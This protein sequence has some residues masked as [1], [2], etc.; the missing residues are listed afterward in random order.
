M[1]ER[2]RVCPVGFAAEFHGV[3]LGDERLNQRL[4]RFAAQCRAAPE[5]SFP[6]IA[7]SQ[8]DLT[9]TYRFL[10]SPTVTLASVLEPHIVATTRRCI[11]AGRVLVIHDTSECEFSGEKRSGLG[12]LRGHDQGFLLHGSLALAADGSRRPLGILGALT[13][14]R[15]ER[16]GTKRPDGARKTGGDY[17]RE[18]GKES[19]RW[20]DTVLGVE[21][22]L[23]EAVK[24]IH[25]MDREADAFHFLRDAIEYGARFV[26]RMAR[27]RVLLDCDDD[28]KLGKTSEVLAACTDIFEL[29]VPLS[30]RAAKPMP[31]S[32]AP[33]EARKAKLAVTG[34]KTRI[35]RPN[36]D[37]ESAE[38]LEVNLVC[39]REVDPPSHGDAVDW[40]LITTEPIDTP[41]QLR[42]V[43][44]AYR[45]RWMIEE[46]F[47]ALKTG[48]AFE[49][50][51][52]ESYD[53][54]TSA[55]GIFLPIAWHLLLLRHDA[56]NTP[57]EPAE[58]VLSPIQLQVLRARLPQIVPPRATASDVLR[59]IAYLGGH[60]T[61]KK[62]G[63]LVLGRGLEK[64]LDLEEG[65]RL[66]TGADP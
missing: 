56:H 1:R 6:D 60:F 11:E 4:T 19:A 45:A 41:Q 62:P 36:Y 61:K 63:W 66:A 5:R 57:R 31:K 9:A 39:V 13:W 54:L 15:T 28:S 43:V 32:P 8:A 29:D 42:A 10:R 33:R 65:W 12:T 50:R 17:H 40:V 55:L 49:K 64:L 18:S 21:Q 51:Q 38:S 26:V 47:K 53:T 24:A 27:D 46:L 25:V 34:T 59:A 7:P 58:R 37:R 52:L 20:W 14:N 30:R 23:G 3:Q 35:A 16:R 2:V 48:C 22:R 44:E